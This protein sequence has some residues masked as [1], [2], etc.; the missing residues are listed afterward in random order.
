MKKRN[1]AINALMTNII[2][3]TQPSNCINVF[4]NL[5]N[6]IEDKDFC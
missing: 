1:E 6:E 4:E 3:N 5:I 2:R